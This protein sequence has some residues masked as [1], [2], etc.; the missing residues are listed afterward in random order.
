MSSSKRASIASSGGEPSGATLGGGERTLTVGQIYGVTAQALPQ[1]QYVALGHVHRPQRV[2]GCA[3]PARYA[4]SLL[5]L[6]FGET[7]HKKGVT[8]IE[9]APG[10]PAEVRE[11]P[12]TAGRRLLDISGT[13]EELT[14]HRD[15]KDTAFLRVTLK[16]DG[17]RPGLADEV[18]ERLPNA[19]EV[20]LDYPRSVADA[21]ATLRG[22]PP[23]EQ[24]AVAI[25]ISW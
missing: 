16:C 5:Q 19:I 20:K 11:V 4:G 17:P 14:A 8:I 24:F 13:M 22:M 6:D 12:I 15:S 10:R 18:R 7:G 25:A 2:P 1:V 9:V 3:V 23:R 21:P